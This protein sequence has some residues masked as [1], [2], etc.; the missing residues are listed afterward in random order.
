MEGYSNK[1]KLNRKYCRFEERDPL[2]KCI[3][4]SDSSGDQ[5]EIKGRMAN[6]FQFQETQTADCGCQEHCT[7]QKDS[8]AF[9]AKRGVINQR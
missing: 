1:Q 5:D 2:I 4:E 3:L 9:I 6:G 7:V 8:E